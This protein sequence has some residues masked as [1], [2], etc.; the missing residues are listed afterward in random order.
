MEYE[1]RESEFDIEDE[2]KSEPEQTGLHNFF[3]QIRCTASCCGVPYLL[4]FSISAWG[5]V[6]VSGGD[7]AEDEEVDVT[8]VDPIVAFCSR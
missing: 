2:D 3:Q 1:E 6:C 4:S 8:T 7:A 5:C